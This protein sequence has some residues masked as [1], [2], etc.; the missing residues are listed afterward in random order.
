MGQRHHQ[1]R[2]V[3]PNRLSDALSPLLYKL[4]FRFDE[5]RCEIGPD[6]HSK[7][8]PTEAVGRAGQKFPALDPSSRQRWSRPS[9]MAS[10]SARVEISPPGWD[11]FRANT[12][13]RVRPGCSASAN[14]EMNISEGCSCM[15]R[16][17]S[18]PRSTETAR[19]LGF[20]SLNYRHE[21]IA[22]SPWL[23]WPTRWR[24]LL[25]RSSVRELAETRTEG[26]T[27]GGSHSF[28]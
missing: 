28:E 7:P 3:G 22:M 4:L 8:Y 11:S 12:L 16:D 24:E 26:G 25:G 13:P 21:R 6:R 15:E 1:Q 9:E 19:H 20:G 17:Q 23:P 10:R 14:A 2:P 27:G 5:S 18:W